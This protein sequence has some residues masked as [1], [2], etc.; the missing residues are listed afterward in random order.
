[1][2]LIY[3]QRLVAALVLSLPLSG[4]GPFL[5]DMAEDRAA[6]A[7]TG[8]GDILVAV[9]DD[10][11]GS[12]YLEGVRLA[13]DE[14]NAGG[15]LLGRR[16]VLMESRGADDFERVRATAL[17]IARNRQVVAVLGHARSQ[18][19]NAAS[20]IYEKAMVLF[21]P[22]FGSSQRLTLHG[23]QFVLRMLPDSTV[24][25]AQSAS[26]ASL[27]GYERMAVLHS[28]DDYSR[29]VAF[30][31]EDAARRFGIDIVFRGAFFADRIDYRHLVGELKG[32][33]FD[34]IYLSTDTEAG[35]RMLRQ[36]RELGLHQPVLGSDILGFGPL[37]TRA[38]AAGD[39]TIVPTAFVPDASPGIKARFVGAYEKIHGRLPT[40]AAAQGYDSLRILAAVIARAGTTE[41]R[42]MATTA[43]FSAP[44]AGVTGIYAFDPRGDIFGKTYRFNLLR[45]GT[46]QGLPGVD[47]PYLLALFDRVL[48]EGR[49]DVLDKEPSA[50]GAERAPGPATLAAD[51]G[52]AAGPV[53]SMPA[54][55]ADAGQTGAAPAGAGSA[56]LAVPASAVA[57][58]GGLAIIDRRRTWLAMVHDILGFGRL[59][60]VVPPTEGGA[61]AA[62]LVRSV[63]SQR[64]FAVD[65]CVLPAM[66]QAAP[67]TSRSEPAT[68]AT[69]TPAPG[70]TSAHGPHPPA[71]EGS[72][73][74][75]GAARDPGASAG[76]AV[77]APQAFPE[78][79]EARTQY[80]CAAVTCYARLATRVNA[81]FVVRDSGLDP[82]LVARLNRV[83]RGFGVPAFAL[84]DSIDGDYGL[85]LAVAPSALDLREP[86][87]LTRFSGILMDLRVHDLNQ[88]LADLPTIGIDLGAL[89][90]LKIH[91]DPRKLTLVSRQ[92]EAAP[93]PRPGAAE[94]PR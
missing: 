92:I 79:S 20:V 34:A 4:C 67:P 44:I 87:I 9:I 37:A 75:A 43:H 22:P 36:L 84:A 15:G 62:A 57:N 85:T 39:G 88:R 45:F 31:F 12:G 6:F 82:A 47:A 48:D 56:P 55:P 1:M 33:G 23:F 86:D 83:L 30:L 50:G 14:V 51:A 42:V 26:V 80:E 32:V 52:T 24:M 16:I 81:M 69:R 49:Q 58:P 19:A 11:P 8:K 53:T 10:R 13:R 66:D 78:C 40:Q 74:P 38:G 46:W 64:G 2:I 91:P 7:R 54:R 28:H 72:V 68:P 29:E 76:E 17:R 60:V 73:W 61:A 90:E 21:L 71:A 93:P 27:F 25:A 94:D 35:A 3:L 63:A 89:E 77:D 41:P 65:A 18:V 59:G 70:A 5:D